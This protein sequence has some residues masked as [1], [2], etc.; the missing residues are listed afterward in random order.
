VT[1]WQPGGGDQGGWNQNQPFGPDAQTQRYG[2]EPYQGSD[3]YADPYGANQADP[4]GAYGP[5]PYQQPGGF[6]A[7]QYPPTGGFPGQQ[8]PPS[9]GF[10]AQGYGPPPPPPKRSKLPMILS[11]T[12]VVIIVGAVVAILIVNKQNNQPAA[13]DDNKSSSSAPT[14]TSG[15]S[16]SSTSSKK[17]APTSGGDHDGWLAIDNKADSGLSYEVPPDWK[18]STA[19]MASGLGV[20]FTGAANYGTYDCEGKGYVRTYAASGDVQGKDGK[21]LDLA[22]TLEDFAKSFAAQGYGPD[23]E[24][25]VPSPTESKVGDKKAMT[26][27]AKVTPKVTIPNCQASEAEV[28]L[29]GVLLETDGK[30]TGVAMLVVVNDLKGNPVDPKPL[31]PSVTQ[32]ILGTVKAD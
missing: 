30:P 15:S 2:G 19:T 20:D 6:P 13:Q 12:A 5:D 18:S 7:Q 27:T 4:Y 8:Y 23:A 14:S 10:P 1:G 17:P 22:T 31:D 16:S 24:V 9:G 3:P 11:L 26:V 32:E 25:D 29:V 21:D 28:A